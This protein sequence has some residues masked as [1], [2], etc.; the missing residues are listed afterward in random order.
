MYVDRAIQV[1]IRQHYP[2]I[3]DN[4]RATMSRAGLPVMLGSN[5]RAA[6]CE[7]IVNN[8]IVYMSR[9]STNIVLTTK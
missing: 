7:A 4:I 1:L 6:C 2:S 8:H 3:G 5:M 9:D